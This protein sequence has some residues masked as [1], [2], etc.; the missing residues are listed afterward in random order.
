MVG[1]TVDYRFLETVGESFSIQPM[2][3]GFKQI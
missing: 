1:G 2:F 3:R